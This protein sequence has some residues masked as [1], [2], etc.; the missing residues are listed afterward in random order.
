MGELQIYQSCRHSLVST[1]GAA[2]WCD[3]V[4]TR[5]RQ[6]GCRLHSSGA[7]FAEAIIPGRDERDQM[8]KVFSLC[9]SPSEQR[10]PG[11]SSLPYFRHLNPEPQYPDRLRQHLRSL[12]S[13]ASDM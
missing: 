1:P 6:L 9:G 3:K 11:V 7:A 13:C 2:A 4:W 5:S 12:D 8:D 10:W